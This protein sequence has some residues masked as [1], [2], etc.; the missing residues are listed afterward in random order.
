[1]IERFA[2]RFGGLDEDGKIFARLFLA[3]EFGK[4]F[5]A[6]AGFELVFV[7]ALGRDDSVF[8]FCFGRRHSDSPR[9]SWRKDSRNSASSG[10]PCALGPMLW[11][12]RAMASAAAI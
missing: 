8:L 10:N 7:A 2:P 12:A 11:L 6:Q 4:P 1:M 3:G 9:S 5:G